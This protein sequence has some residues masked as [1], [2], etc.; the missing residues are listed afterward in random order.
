MMPI[1]DPLQRA[2]HHHQ[3]GQ[4]AT[5]E[6]IYRQILAA[7]PHHPDANYLLGRLALQCGQPAQAVQLAQRAMASNP[8]HPLLPWLL[9][10]AEQQQGHTDAA[11]TAYRQALALKPDLLDAL[12]DLGNL[13]HSGRQDV[14][15]MSVYRQILALQPQLAAVQNNLGSLYKEHGDLPAALACCR[16]AVQHEPTEAVFHFNL[17]NSC[18]EAGLLQEAETAYRQALQLGL[19]QAVIWYSLGG[20]QQQLGQ[21]EEALNCLRQALQLDSGYATAR[22]ALAHLLQQRC[23]WDELAAHIPLLRQALS[24]PLEERTLISPFSLL[25]LPDTTPA[26]H[27]RCAERWAHSRYA[28]IQPNIIKTAAPAANGQH[29]D[30]QSSRK[31]R[32]GYLSADFHDHATAQLMAEIFELHDRSRFEV[33]AFSYGPETGDTMRARLRLAFDHFVDLQADA[34][35]AAAEKIRAH[36]IDILIDLKGYTEHSRSAIL[37]H[38]PAPI[39]VNYLGYPGTMGAPFID[40]LL[41]DDFII[42]VGQ[43]ALYSEQVIRLP[44]CYQPNDRQ[45]LRPPAPT[46]AACGLPD[47]AVVFCCFNH[48]YKI[49]PEIFAIWCSLLQAVPGSVLWLLQSND[50]AMTNLRQAAS[51]HGIAAERLIAAPKLAHA[52]HLARLQCADLFL[53]TLPVN[54]HTTASDALW[55]GLPVVTCAQ[56]GFAARVAGSLLHTSGLPDL[57]ADTLDGYRDLALQLAQHPQQRSALRDRIAAARSNAPLFDSLHFTRKLE[58]AYLQMLAKQ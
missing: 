8:L 34:H 3:N 27:K 17:A 33:S 21:A 1:S 42:P 46:R 54:A 43:D 57:V 37:A 49:T 58:D 15:T 31:I 53:D 26:E 39:Q 51:G 10:D 45:R 13:L 11:I 9:A 32:I 36:G 7:A 2:L 19:N 55:M 25:V 47:E 28:A 38:R 44:G 30:Q 4:L 6:A 35:A 52:D 56:Q 12:L 18:W 22:M 20:V 14:E 40:Y 41:A 50:A 16:L 5:A 23:Q 24:A 48:S 29:P